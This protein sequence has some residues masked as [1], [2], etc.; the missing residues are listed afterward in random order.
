MDFFVHRIQRGRG[1]ANA[2]SGNVKHIFE[3]SVMRGQYDGD[4]EA[5]KEKS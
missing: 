5:R 2:K 3:L 1:V 4:N